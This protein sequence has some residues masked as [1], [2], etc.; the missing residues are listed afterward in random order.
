MNHLKYALTFGTGFVLLL[1]IRITSMAAENP[2]TAAA[3]EAAIRQ[4]GAAYVAALAR[5]DAKSLTEYWTKDGTYYDTSGQSFNARDTIKEQFTQGEVAESNR[6]AT[7]DADSSIRF[8]TPDVAI[9][10]GSYRPTSTSDD[11]HTA[12]K[13]AAIWVKTDRGCC[14][15]ACV[16]GTS[17]NDI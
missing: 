16:N 2:N 11:D 15:I 7:V 17:A 6:R 9:E 4:T 12:G 5:G 13:Y 3:E 8:V 10:E 1:A 14:W